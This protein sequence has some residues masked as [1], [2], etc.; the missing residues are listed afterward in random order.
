MKMYTL[1]EQYRETEEMPRRIAEE[2][3]WD[4]LPSER[5]RYIREIDTPV[6]IV[7][8]TDTTTR[9]NLEDDDDDF[10][11]EGSDNSYPEG[12]LSRDIDDSDEDGEEDHSGQGGDFGGGGSSS[13]W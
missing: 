6:D 9:I 12:D 2:T 10:D 7:E 13:D 4:M 1:K 11:E 3:Y 5:N 8:N